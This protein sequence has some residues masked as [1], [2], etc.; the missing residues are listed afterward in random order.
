MASL[1]VA[2]AQRRVSMLGAHA[3]VAKQDVQ[4]GLAT[5]FDLGAAFVETRKIIESLSKGYTSR[6]LKLF[7]AMSTL[8]SESEYLM[9]GPILW[10]NCLLDNADSSSTAAVGSLFF[11]FSD[12]F[13][14]STF[15]IGMFLA[16]AMR[17][18][19]LFRITRNYRGRFTNVSVILY[20][21]SKT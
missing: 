9:L 7:V 13:Y 15:N 10:E 18:E 20:L 4:A 19:D 12:L 8:I 14:S 3:F 16:H 5:S 21:C 6:A 11:F 17:R 1:I 2:Y